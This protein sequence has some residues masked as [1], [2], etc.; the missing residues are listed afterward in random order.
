MA[1]WSSS[2][3]LRTSMMG[4]RFRPIPFRKMAGPEALMMVRKTGGSS[5]LSVVNGVKDVLP[6]LR[7]LHARGRGY[8]AD[9]RS[10][11]FR[12][13]IAE[14]RA[15]G[16]RDGGGAD[17]ADDPAVP[18]QLAADADHS[19]V[20]SAVD[21]HRGAGDVLHGADAEH[22]DAGRIRAGGGNSGGQLDG[23]DRKHRT[24]SGCARKKA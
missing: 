8:Q 18:G 14:Q 3:M 15:D 6:D 16:R 13:G 24:P 5:T 20:D 1:R 21:H 9:F 17:R 23:R 2:A 11:D 19:G 12:E 4:I 7:K 22:D 10:V